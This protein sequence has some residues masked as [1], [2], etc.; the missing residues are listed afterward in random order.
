MQTQNEI[1][2]G[3]T[4][5]LIE[6]LK[7]G[8]IP[9]RKPWT[10]I[11][12]PRTPTNLVSKHRYSGVNVLL[13]LLAEQHHGWPVSYWGTFNQ[14]RQIG[15]RIR[16]G[17]KATTIVYWKQ[18]K[19]TETDKNGDEKER[20]IPLLKTWSIFNVAQVEGQAVEKFNAKP[21]LKT[22]EGIDRAEFDA[23]VA[24][25]GARI[26]YGH[27]LAAYLPLEDRI[28]MPEEGRFDTFSDFA[29]TLLHEASHWSEK[30]LDWTG[31]YA[32]NELRAEI[33]SSFLMSALGVPHSDDLQNVKAYIQ[34]WIQALEN[35]P[36]FIFQA[37]TAASKS[38]D[39]VLSF[40]RP[41]AEIDADLDAA[42]VASVS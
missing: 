18:I 11:E 2:Q 37:S 39:F 4:N 29:A 20:T 5:R 14:F 17:E 25:T 34:S 27:E 24:A 13:T 36:K 32:L 40:S 15:C 23:A 35:D 19:K 41:P 42:T 30:R 8:R 7:E 1:R 31:S 21:E 22:F 26:D 33:S 3:I 12:G 38:A 28:V 9:W 16:K 10:G 6:S